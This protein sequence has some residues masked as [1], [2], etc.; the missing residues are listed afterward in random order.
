MDQANTVL[1][2]AKRSKRCIMAASTV[3]GL[4]KA[5][6]VLKG[7]GQYRN[8]WK[9]HGGLMKASDAVRLE[10]EL[11]QSLRE[12]YE[13]TAAIFRHL[14]LVRPGAAEYTD[15]GFRTQIEKLSG[16]DPTFQ[17]QQVELAQPAKSN[18]L[19]FWM[20]DARTMCRALPFFRLGV[21]QRPQETSFYVFNRV[22]NGG[23]R[24]VSY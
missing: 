13:I 21:P 24:W 14:Q 8:S 23:F 10:S 20:T 17:R 16:S 3:G 11:Q 4:G 12:F 6:E 2:A 19:A 5:T 1:G 9:G 7:P 15:A 22:E 18:A